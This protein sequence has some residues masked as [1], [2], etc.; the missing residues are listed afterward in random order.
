MSSLTSWLWRKVRPGDH[1]P[2]IKPDSNGSPLQGDDNYEKILSDLDERIRKQEILLAELTI[3]ERH[4][5][6]AWL[7][8][9]IPAYVFYLVGYFTFLNPQDDI[10]NIWLL[11]TVPL[12]LFPFLIYYGRKFIVLWFKAKKRIQDQL[13]ETLR[14]QQKQKVE[15]L[16]KKTGYYTTKG[17]I[18]R[19]ESPQKGDPNKLHM[20]GSPARG[21]PT[22]MPP[23][24]GQSQLRQRHASMPSPPTGAILGNALGSPSMSGTPTPHNA[25]PGQALGPN[26]G[27]PSTIHSSSQ[28]GTPNT[29]QRNWYDKVVDA[30]IGDEQ[31]QQKYALICQQCFEHN[32]LVLPEE[33]GNAKFRCLKCGFFNARKS[34]LAT[35]LSSNS[36][37]V[38]P[39]PSPSPLM[40][41]TLSQDSVSRTSMRS[42]SREPMMRS[43]DDMSFSAESL[44]EQAPEMSQTNEDALDTNFTP[45]ETEVEPYTVP[46]NGSEGKSD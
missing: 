27:T 20:P 26:G 15:E 4:V 34:R 24:S 29:T 28:F 12:L 44:P 21:T 9:S 5:L 38:S 18:E 17:L 13:L 40:G 23:G 2:S 16:K 30:I 31:P 22:G 43:H 45:P 25:T 42:S 11:K 6:V 37:D 33:Y 39:P 46:G 36:A 1:P 19:Y 10:L 35:A 7:Y 14:T 3:K 8:Y 32:G 41:R